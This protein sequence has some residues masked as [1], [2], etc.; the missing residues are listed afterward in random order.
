MHDSI[1]LF[2]VRMDSHHQ[3]SLDGVS[4]RPRELRTSMHEGLLDVIVVALF[5]FRVRIKSASLV[6]LRT[7]SAISP[8]RWMRVTLR[9]L[10]GRRG[11]IFVN[12][13]I[14]TIV[15]NFIKIMLFRKIYIVAIFMVRC[16]W[17]LLT[18]FDYDVSLQSNY[19]HYIDLAIPSSKY[20]FPYVWLN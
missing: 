5:S 20:L 13:K 1:E 8:H 16:T 9:S 3:Y 18:I 11:N 4:V 7:K 19:N 17:K 10:Q 12:L 6:L 14:E 15:L 2:F